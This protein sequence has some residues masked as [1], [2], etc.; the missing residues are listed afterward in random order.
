MKRRLLSLTALVLCIALLLPLSAAG[1]ASPAFTDISGHWAEDTIE[2]FADKGIISGFPDGSFRPN[3][4]VTRAE[5]AAIVTRAF[6]LNEEASFEFPDVDPGAWY[7]EYLKFAARFIPTHQLP[8]EFSEPTFRGNSPAHRSD[9]AEASVLITM[10]I[11]DLEVD[12]PPLE[13]LV[14]QVRDTFRDSDYRYGDISFP[15]VQRL[16]RYTWLAVHLG[17]MEG[18]DGG[19]FRPAWGVRRAEV[20]TIIDRMLAA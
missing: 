1:T 14:Q 6:E 3:R 18:R 17:I 4:L 12:V 8:N 20:L 19:Y 13:E 11:N 5:F 16:F 10:H 7:Y 15:N 9:A 2:R